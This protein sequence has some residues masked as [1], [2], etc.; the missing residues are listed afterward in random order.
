[1][2]HCCDFFMRFSDSLREGIDQIV[3]VNTSVCKENTFS[4]IAIR[5]FFEDYEDESDLIEDALDSIIVLSETTCA[6]LAVWKSY[7]WKSK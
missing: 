4:G 2:E 3:A 7:D 5:A 6:L 1:M